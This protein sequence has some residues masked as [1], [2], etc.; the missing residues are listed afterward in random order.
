MNAMHLPAD[1]SPDGDRDDTY[2]YGDIEEYDN[3]LA[4][5][6]DAA[7]MAEEVLGNL[8]DLDA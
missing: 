5:L 4:D 1:Y 6:A 2:R 3:L 8:A 7:E